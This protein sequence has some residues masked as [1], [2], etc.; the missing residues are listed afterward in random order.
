MNV[1]LP[2]NITKKDLK[3]SLIEIR[4]A[5]EKPK[6]IS[7]GFDPDLIQVDIEDRIEVQKDNY[8]IRLPLNIKLLRVIPT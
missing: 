1:Q 3:L 2:F 6:E 7:T 8:I 4:V 5:Y